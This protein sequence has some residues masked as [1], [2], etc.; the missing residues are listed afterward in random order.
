MD[1]VL[2]PHPNLTAIALSREERGFFWSCPWRGTRC[3]RQ[4]ICGGYWVGS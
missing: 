3:H 4:F 2:F 1:R